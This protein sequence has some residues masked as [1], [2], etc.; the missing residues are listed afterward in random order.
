[1]GEGKYQDIDAL[2]ERGGGCVPGGGVV[3]LVCFAGATMG[4]LRFGT[5]GD[6]GLFFISFKE[7]ATYIF[8]RN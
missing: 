6:N 2:R 1:M 3:R 7:Q 8:M 5:L 4:V